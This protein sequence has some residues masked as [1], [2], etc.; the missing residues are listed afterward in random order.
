MYLNSIIVSKFGENKPLENTPTL[1]FCDGNAGVYEFNLIQVYS[2][3]S[4]S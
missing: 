4:L 3:I 1:I 2:T